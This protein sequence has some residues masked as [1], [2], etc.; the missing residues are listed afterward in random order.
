MITE[1]LKISAGA[2]VIAPLIALLMVVAIVPATV[3]LIRWLCGGVFV[4]KCDGKV[5]GTIRWLTFRPVVNAT[6]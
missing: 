3:L 1:I 2:V 5:T 4:V 6:T